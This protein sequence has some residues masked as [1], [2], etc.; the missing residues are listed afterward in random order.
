MHARIFDEGAAMAET[1]AELQAKVKALLATV[2]GRPSQ[3][4]LREINER[5]A[6]MLR[7]TERGDRR[8]AS[9]GAPAG[10]P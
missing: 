8:S 5:L 7:R 9:G 6:E 1:I 3:Y 2:V 10:H 4:R